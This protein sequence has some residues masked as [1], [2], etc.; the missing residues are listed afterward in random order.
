[1]VDPI[2][3]V[4]ICVCKFFKIGIGLDSFESSTVSSVL[5]GAHT[6]KVDQKL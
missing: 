2:A 5:G 3:L 1:M 4:K 6:R